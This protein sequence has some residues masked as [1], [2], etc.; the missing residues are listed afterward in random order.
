M[1][2][3]ES[4]TTFKISDFFTSAMQK[5][6]ATQDK[7]EGKVKQMQGSTSGAFSKMK[8]GVESFKLKN[9]EAIE[10]IANQVPGAS[11]AL[12]M[13][14]NPYALAGAAAVGAGVAIKKATGYAQDWEAKMAE[15][16]VTAQLGSCDLLPQN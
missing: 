11:G 5:I 9:M 4:I 2:N 12:A 13:L 15:V 16:N 7:F 10:G 8:A 6:I 14:A 1:A 3:Q